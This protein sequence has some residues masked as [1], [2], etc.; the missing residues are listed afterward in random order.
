MIAAAF[1]SRRNDQETQMNGKQPI[2]M[3]HLTRRGL[4]SVAPFALAAATGLRPAFAQTQSVFSA[5]TEAFVD[6]VGVCG[7]FA[8][9]NGIYPESF[10][11]ILPELEAL[12]VGHLRD[13][14]L[15]TARDSRN[16]PAF[17][18]LRRIV[19]ANVRLTIICYDNLNPYVSTPL[20]RI[21]DFYDW[22]DGGIEVFEGSNEPTLTKDPANAP[23]ISAEHQAALFATIRS[24]PAVSNVPL[25]APSYIQANTELALNLQNVCDFGN[26]HPY[27]GME[28]P[29]TTGRGRSPNPSP[30][31]RI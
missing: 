21:A 14:G 3:G 15:I 19:A 11:R 5:G 16:S 31:R 24:T 6:S 23:R 18:R 1:I 12:G 13:E 9:T 26:I 20:N 7:H 10:E 28:H 2:T 4:L 25:V 27:A 8:R 29:E 22:C 30:P 17:Q